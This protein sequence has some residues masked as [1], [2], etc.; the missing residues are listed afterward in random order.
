MVKLD[1]SGI[2]G[3]YCMKSVGLVRARGSGYPGEV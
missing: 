2:P 3:C 1:V